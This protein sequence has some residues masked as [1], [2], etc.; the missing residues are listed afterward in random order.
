MAIRKGRVFK[1]KKGDTVTY[2]LNG[3]EIQRS[4][5]VRITPFTSAELVNQAEFGLMNELLKPVKPF[6]KRGFEL[7]GK[8]KHSAGYSM[9]VGY[10][11]KKAIKHSPLGNEIEYEKVLFSQ[12][13]ITVNAETTVIVVEGGLEFQWDAAL[14]QK[15][16]KRN[17]HAMLLAYCPEKQSAFFELSGAR[18]TAGRDFLEV[19]AY[20]QPVTLELYITFESADRKSI[21]NSFYIGQLKY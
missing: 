3:Q 16:M 19:T 2:T 11:K 14:M 17:D 12:G 1:G 21:S 7:Q 5:G 18:R 4:I 20:H 6:I 10:N 13:E 15:G 8:K 9:A